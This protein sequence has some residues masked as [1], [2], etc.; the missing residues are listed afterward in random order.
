MKKN[1]TLLLLLFLSTFI[2]AQNNDFLN[3]G[4]DFLWSNT[5]NWSLGVVPNTTNTSIV[6]IPLIVESLVDVD[7]TV[8]KIQTTFSTPGDASIAGNNVLS[9]DAG[10][11]ALYGIENVSSTNIALIFKGKVTINNSTTVSISNTLMRNQNGSSNS[12]VFAEG[13]VLRLNTPLE[14]RGGSSNAFAFNGSLEGNTP[15]RVNTNTV[16]TFGSSSNNPNFEGDIVWVGGASVIVNTADN[17]TFLPAARKIQINAINGSIVI[18]GANVFKGNISVNGSNNFTFDVNKN[19][20]SMGFINFSGGTANGTLN[21]VVDNGVTELAFA[22]TSA[23]EWNAGTLNITGYKPGVIRFG[24]DATGLTA[25][26]L[27]QITVDGNG[28]AVALDSNGYLVNASSLSV[29]E[30]LSNADKQITYPTITSNNLYFKSAQNGF[31]I[32]DINGRV[33]IQN[34]S[35]NQ[36]EVNVITLPTGMYFIRFDSNRTEKFIKR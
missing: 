30:F 1:Y 21:L 12:I 25:T 35:E 23:S 10:E 28:G 22:N 8:K 9:I 14:T 2:S 33:L 15:L 5:A 29:D 17:N 19:Q 13:S 6:R 7:V 4:G 32:Y 18:N 11:N 31:K 24:T 20:N 26:Q 36:K 16:S 34:K 3:G 27:S